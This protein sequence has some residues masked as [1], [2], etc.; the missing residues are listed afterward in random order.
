MLSEAFFLP[1]ASGYRFC[2][3]RAPET[4]DR[5]RGALLYV[6][7]FAE[8]MNKSRRAI[9]VA[10]CAFAEAGWAVLQIDLLGCGDSSG[11][12]SDATWETWCEDVVAGYRWLESRCERT[13]ALWGLRLGCVL[14][15]D[16][17]AQ[18]E[19]QP[20][21]LLW[22]PVLSGRIHLTQ[23]LRL[24]V[25]AEALDDAAASRT[26]VSAL[27]Q[28]LAHG[29]TLEIAGYPVTPALAAG[30]DSA[31]LALPPDYK[32]RLWWC[33]VVV[34]HDTVSPASKSKIATLETRGCSV[35]TVV[36][37]DAPFWQTQEIAECPALVAASTHALS[38]A[39]TPA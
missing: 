26:K 36:V 21:L 12:L 28:S 9:A 7:P 2:V 22:Q 3:L 37:P 4:P 39:G 8:E 35:E 27:R 32:G 6:H 29:E 33:E 34:N 25:A 15:S 1:T 38:L 14:A 5:L 24:K 20:N 10:A 23:F 19:T 16:T 30:M 11:E 18:L 17:A 13:P 31:E